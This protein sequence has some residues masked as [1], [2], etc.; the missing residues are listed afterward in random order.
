MNKEVYKANDE[1]ELA[2]TLAHEQYEYKVALSDE[3]GEIAKKPAHQPE[4]T[5][6]VSCIS[7][8]STGGSIAVG[9]AHKTHETMCS[10][11]SVVA[12]WNMFVKSFSS[13]RPSL[14]LDSPVLNSIT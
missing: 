12:V 1:F 14:T 13:S 3:E 7:W 6:M 11:H 5:K 9:Y 2:F 4:G 8:S 10:H